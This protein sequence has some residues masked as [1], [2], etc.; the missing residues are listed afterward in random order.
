MVLVM[1]GAPCLIEMDEAIASEPDSQVDPLAQIISP[2]R[3][4]DREPGIH[5]IACDATQSPG[6]NAVEGEDYECGVFTVPQNWDEPDGRSLDLAFVV[7]K[8]TEK[9]PASDA[10]VFLSGG[11]GQSAMSKPIGG[12]QR[13]QADHD[14][15][16]LDQRGTGFSQRLG[17]EECLVLALQNDAPPAQIEALQVAAFNPLVEGSTPLKMNELDIP[18]LNGICWPQFTK[19]GLD[20]S[21]FTTAASARDVVEL[22]KALNYEGFTLHGVSYGT[23]L[24][25]T[26]MAQLPTFDDAPAL[27][28]V[29]LDSAFPPSIYTIAAFPRKDHDFMLQLLAEC[30][31]DAGCRQAYPNL[32]NRLAALLD[33]L[34]DEPLTAKGETVTLDDVVKQ[35]TMVEA[36]Q[37][38]YLPRM[39]VE[40][41]AGVLDTYLALREGTV[42]A[43]FPAN[44]AGDLDRSDPVQAFIVDAYDALGGGVSGSEMVVYLNFSLIDADPLAALRA[45]VEKHFPGDAGEQLNAKLATLTTKAIA[46]SPYVA[47]LQADF[48]AEAGIGDP[49]DLARLVLAK[50]RLSVAGRLAQPFFNTIHC[51]EDIPFERFEDGVNSYHDLAFP[52]L[53]NL[54]L[55]QT[56]ADLC[57]NWPVEAAPIQ[58]KDPV[59]STVPTLVLQGA[60]DRRTPVF[61]GKR[62]ARELANSTYVLVPQT[63]HEI[64][65]YAGDCV[66]Q[67]AGAFIQ[68][69]GA[70]LDLSCLD[71]RKPQWALPGG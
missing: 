67:I 4:S 8:A 51:V 7:V 60:Y 66:G 49:E 16:R 40:L 70:E 18:V 69:P 14:I 46:E 5:N 17:Y 57:R 61:M 65:S 6:I 15:I 58:V 59:S 55:S 11:P 23:R 31:A 45:L 20:L 28:S 54:E 13:L 52:Q 10:L 50:Q 19:Q 12:Y 42:G 47:Q 35:L 39:I 22:L 33:K 44:Y 27:R 26:I 62:A 41:E 36:S 1:L 24:A 64:W 56:M 2:P 43:D 30:R 37:A 3:L 25:M 63:G 53:S 34:E 71:G 48:A 21:Q 38:A 9:Q 29:V 32:D 68:D